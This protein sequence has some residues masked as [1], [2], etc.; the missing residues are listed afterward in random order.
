MLYIHLKFFFKAVFH[1]AIYVVYSI[2]IFLNWN[3]IKQK[4]LIK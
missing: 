3:K 2:T 4:N 1:I